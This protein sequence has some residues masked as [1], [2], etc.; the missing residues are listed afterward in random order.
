[1][2]VGKLQTQTHGT[3]FDTITRQTFTLVKI[4][5]IPQETAQFFE[6][7]V[8]LLMKRIL[9]NLQEARTLITQRDVLLPLLVSEGV[10]G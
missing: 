8:E 3:I 10:R 1:M 6:S 7:E 9:S 4:I 2:S 5:L